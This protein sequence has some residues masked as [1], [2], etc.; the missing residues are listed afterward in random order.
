MSTHLNL[1]SLLLPL[2]LFLVGLALSSSASAQELQCVVTVSAP[3]VGSDQQVYSQ[4]QDAITKYVN[5]RKWTD[6]KYLPEERIKCRIQILIN[7]RPAVDEF[8]GSLQLQLIRPVYNSTYESLVLNIQDKDFNFNYVPFTPLEFS[9]NNYV[10]E[11][12]ALLNFYCYILV[13]FDQ[14]TFQMSSGTPYFEQANQVVNLA[15]EEGR[16]G[17]R[18]FDGQQNRYWLVTDML[19]N[20]LRSVHNV[21]YVYHRQG[22]DQMQKNIG[23]GRASILGALKELQK[24]NQRYPA[25]Y[26]TRVFITAKQQEIQDIFRKADMAQKRQLV[27]VMDKLDPA[28]SSDYQEILKERN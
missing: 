8:R 19:D 11:L 23:L 9:E 13:G 7:E 20:S 5:F 16:R 18:G 6:L 1:R 25:K 15:G 21:L 17:W 22:L 12:T 24:L 3:T 10:S 28:N 14:E 27:E 26:I 4:M 2:A